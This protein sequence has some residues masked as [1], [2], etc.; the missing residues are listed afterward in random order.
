M[1]NW[2]SLHRCANYDDFFPR[3]THAEPSLFS[4]NK[5]HKI[6]LFLNRAL[7]VYDTTCVVQLP[8]A[9]YVDLNF[10]LSNLPGRYFVIDYNQIEMSDF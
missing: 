2:I 5:K 10:V 4:Q 1:K 7:Y 9:C 6:C 3:C 8:Y